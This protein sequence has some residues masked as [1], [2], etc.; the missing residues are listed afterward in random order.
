[1]SDSLISTSEGLAQFRVHQPAH[2]AGGA[3]AESAAV[4]P[5]IAAADVVSL[6]V[7]DTVL[8][9]ACGA[10]KALYLWL[11]RRLARRG[12]ISCTPEVFARA[13]A[14]TEDQ[15]WERAGGMDAC[16]YLRDFYAEIVRYLWLDDGLVD[17]L[18]AAELA[19]E[20][21]VLRPAPRA[22]QL[23][24]HAVHRG[25]R[26]VF[27]SDTYFTAE[28]IEKQLRRHRLWPQGAICLSSSD[29]RCCKAR[30]GLFDLLLDRLRVSARAV[31]HAG[32]NAHSDVKMSRRRGIRPMHLPEGCL[33]RYEQLLCEHGW[34]SG[35][36]SSALAGASR[37]AR[38]HTPASSPQE[39]TLRDAAAGVAAPILIGYVLWVLQRSR[40]LGILKVFFCARDG[41]VMQEVAQHLLKRLKW[42][43]EVAYLHVSRRA[44]NL[45]AT[46]DVNDEESAWVFRDL[47]SLSPVGFL[48]RFDLQW[49]EA[50]AGME[51][52][53]IGQSDRRLPAE[54]G[55]DLRKLL[56]SDGIRRLI[57]ERAAARRSIVMQYLQQEGLLNGSR[58]ALVDFGGVGSQMRALHALLTEAGQPAPQLFLMGLDSP[59][60]L[61]GGALQI[62]DTARWLADTEC[63]LYDHRRQRGIKR[64]RGFGT[65]V[66][67]FCAADHG[68]VTGYQVSDGQVKPSLAADVDGPVVD[69]GLP[70]VRKTLRAVI[71]HLVVDDDLVDPRGD[72][73][74]PAC[75]A[76][77]ALWS[78]P[79]VEEAMSWGAFPI[80]GA[81]ADGNVG[82][83]LVSRY[84]W[85]SVTRGVVR[86]RFP[87]LGWQHWYEGSLRIS[88]ASLRWAMAAAELFFR[89]GEKSTFSLGQAAARAVRS[90]LGK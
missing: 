69:W 77:H 66:Q 33:N 37:L 90:L 63:Y 48:G 55:I 10:P 31:V 84:S 74:E 52:L 21:E 29:L 56:Q 83:P 50:A 5:L 9:R 81:E 40:D 34:A 14:R 72:L 61:Y 15:V 64:A 85:Y 28:F 45:A 20:E 17:T 65:C 12:T 38:L 86:R 68:S 27:T 16:V 78:K 32:D 88:P 89:S 24:E 62:N 4:S 53:G 87:N 60:G 13:R 11:G 23:I 3:A 1:M 39:A 26:V 41:Q 7:F 58:I 18:T 76:I 75:A 2:G 47:G 42:P 49:E 6:D 8:T 35:G 30:G 70:V 36:L 71:E 44:V 59:G 80:E 19:L 79:T 25:K 67:M 51:A 82:R 54:H 46:F 73:R 43:V 22:R 57:L